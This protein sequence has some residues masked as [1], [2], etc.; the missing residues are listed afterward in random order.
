MARILTMWRVNPLAPWPT[1]PSKYLELMEKMWAGIDEAMRK[2]DVE[3]MG[4][5]P[6][7]H[8]G[9]TIGKGEPEDGYKY[10]MMFS[11]Y[12]VFEMHE[13]VSYEKIKEIT[14][15]VVKAQIAAMKK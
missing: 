10:S 3:E 4:G 9:Y 8:V 15:A 14:R 13:I 1:D 7:G 5:F 12:F 11:P 2:G 6:D